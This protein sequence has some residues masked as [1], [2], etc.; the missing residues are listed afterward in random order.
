MIKNRELFLEDPLTTLKNAGYTN[1][2]ETML[3]LDA[4]SFVFD[5]QSGSL[6]HALASPG[7]APQVTAISDW[8]INADEPPLLDYNL[9]NSRDPALF[10]A[11]TPYR[12]SD[13]DPLIIGLDLT[14]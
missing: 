2:A 3:G 1:L 14:P 6:D 5:G 13:H 10:D 12:T 11:A 4:Y 7:L 9:E 8:H